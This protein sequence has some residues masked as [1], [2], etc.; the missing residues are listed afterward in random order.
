MK[1]LITFI[2]SL[3]VVS[4]IPQEEYKVKA[5]FSEVTK[6]AEVSPRSHGVATTASASPVTSEKIETVPLPTTTNED[7]QAEL[8]RV[9]ESRGWGAHIES[10]KSLAYRESGL[11]PYA[12]NAS[13]GACGIGQA[14]PCSKMNCELGDA[15]CQLIWMA[16]YI[17]RRY[18]NP[19][20]AWAFWQ[21]RTPIEGVDV[22]HWY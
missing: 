9:A 14:M 13:S 2:L 18:G 8:V 1:F 10:W 22:G 6:V 20:S 7:V 17:E 12:L 4:L 16:D 5:E 19:S 11:N 3:A 15:R 21:S